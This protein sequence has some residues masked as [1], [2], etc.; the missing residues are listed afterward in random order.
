MSVYLRSPLTSHDL[1]NRRSSLILPWTTFIKI[2]VS[3]GEERPFVEPHVKHFVIFRDIKFNV[4]WVRNPIKLLQTGKNLHHGIEEFRL[5][6]SIRFL[7]LYASMVRGNFEGPRFS[8]KSLSVC[9]L[10]KSVGGKIS[11]YLFKFMKLQDDL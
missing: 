9:T 2:H 5:R 7:L 1:N 6:A 3:I 8:D 4:F 11:I 10:T